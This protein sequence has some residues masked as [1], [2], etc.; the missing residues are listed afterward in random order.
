[1][2]VISTSSAAGGLPLGIV[3]TSGESANLIHRAMTVLTALFPDGPFYGQGS[4]ANVITDDSAA[5][6]DGLRKVWANS[7]LFLCIFHFLQSMWRWLLSADNKIPK[8]ERQYLMNQ[9]R[10][11]VYAKTE[12]S[13]ESEYTLFQN[14]LIVKKHKNFVSHMEKTWER[15]QEWAVCFRD[16]ALMRGIGTNNYAESGIRILKDIVFKRVKAYNLIQL[17]EFL[18]ITFEVNYERRLLAVA[19]NRVDRY[20]SLRYKGLG[21]SNV[22]HNDIRKSTEST[23]MYIVKSQTRSIEYE[24]DTERWTCTCS[25]GRTGHSS[26]EPCKHQHAVANKHNLTAPNLV[27]YFNASGRH[28]HAIVALGPEKAGDMSFYCGMTEDIQ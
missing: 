27:P 20:I 12:T 17:F 24:V 2:F 3:I 10:K 1:M 11:L 18:T 22:D 9:V 13:L 7:K 15:R 5:E 14:N 6:R 8:D 21:A 25:V 4:P 19:Y 26:G 28:L 23:C 16:D